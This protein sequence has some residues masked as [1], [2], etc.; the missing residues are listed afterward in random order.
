MIFFIFFSY[1]IG[2]QANR[3][4]SSQSPIDRRYDNSV[5]YSFG[6][7]G[8]PRAYVYSLP[9]LPSRYMPAAGIDRRTEG[10][11]KAVVPKPLQ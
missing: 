1:I 4:F 3:W 7:N 10:I 5:S 11:Y 8:M 2:L 9:Y 6:E